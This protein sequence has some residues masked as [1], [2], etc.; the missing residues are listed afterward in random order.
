MIDSVFAP[1]QY[2]IVI[3]GTCGVVP[4]ELELMYPY[5][6]YDYILGKCTGERVKRD[7]VAIETYRIAGFLEKTRCICRKRIAYCIGIFRE[8]VVRACDQ[9]GILNGSAAPT[10]PTIERMWSDDCP[11]SE[12]SLSM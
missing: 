3:F 9:T 5:A 7:F 6:H 4:A 12:G 11:F 8:A 10:C 2:H 1:E